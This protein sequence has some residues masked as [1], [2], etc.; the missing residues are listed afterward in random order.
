MLVL[1]GYK[2]KSIAEILKRA[3]NT[4][5]ELPREKK[6]ANAFRRVG[7]MRPG[8]DAAADRHELTPLEVRPTYHG[9][10]GYHRYLIKEGAGLL[11]GGGGG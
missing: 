8:S 5:A 9:Y 3:K 10:H 4:L 1:C 2:D 7:S 6:A 11:R